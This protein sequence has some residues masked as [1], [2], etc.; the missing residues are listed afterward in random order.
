MQYRYHHINKAFE[1]S[2]ESLLFLRLYNGIFTVSNLAP[3]LSCDPFIISILEIRKITLIPT[4]IYRD[5]ILWA[6]IK[7][8]T[9]SQ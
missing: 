8:I 6:F 3:F 1:D 7:S 5:G 4:K 2:G 9:D